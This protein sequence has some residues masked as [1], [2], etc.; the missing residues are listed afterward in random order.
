MTDEEEKKIA[1][2]LARVM[3]L[4]CVRNTRLEDIHAGK[5]SVTK[6]GDYRDVVVIDAEGREIPRPE[7]SHISD[8]QMRDL[9]KDVVNRL[10]T[11][12]L[13]VDDPQFQDWI[14]L[15]SAVASRWTIPSWKHRFCVR[16]NPSVRTTVSQKGDSHLPDSADQRLEAYGCFKRIT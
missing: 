10:Y 6:T 2:E 7:A 11:F 8:P 3:A 16:S 15:W 1:A 9:M 12:M 14:A 4:M 13:K 5:H